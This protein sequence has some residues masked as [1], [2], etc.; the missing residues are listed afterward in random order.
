[1]C[2]YKHICVHWLKLVFQDQGLRVL[3]PGE[4]MNESGDRNSTLHVWAIFLSFYLS[5]AE[6]GVGA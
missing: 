5:G 2:V 6:A 4:G 3:F 1:M